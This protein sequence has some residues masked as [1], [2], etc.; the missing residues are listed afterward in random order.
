MKTAKLGVNFGVAEEAEKPKPKPT[1]RR[2]M[3]TQKIN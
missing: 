1:L 2:P 3:K